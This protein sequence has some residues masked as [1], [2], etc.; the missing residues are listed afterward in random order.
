VRERA[1]R[2]LDQ[3][4]RAYL[5]GLTA[6]KIRGG[7]KPEDALRAARL[8]LGGVEQVKEQVRDVRRGAWFERLA[9]DVR[10]GARLL[11]RSPGFTAV[12]VATLALGIGANTALFSVVHALLLRPLPYRD[13]DRLVYIS[14]TRPG[15]PVA[16][17]PSTDF[18]NWQSNG[19]LFE[20]MEGFGGGGD[21]NL[22]G[23][24]EPERISGVTVTA[25]FLDL[26]GVRPAMGRNFTREEDRP[27]GPRAIVLSDALWRR[28]FGAAGDVVGKSVQLDERNYA[29]V[30]VLPASF[31]FPDNLYR[32][33]LLIP[34]R[35]PAAPVWAGPG[36][37]LLKA[38]ARLKPGGTIP[39]LRAELAALAAHTGS[40]APAE[41][42]EMHTNMQVTL[43]PLRE[44]LAGDARRV[45]L[46][47][48]AAVAMV[49]L[50]GCLNIANLEIGRAISRRKEMAL[51]AALGAGRARMARQLITES[52]L[53]SA[54]GA[55]AGLLLGYEGLRLL[56]R[57]LP[58]NL[59]LMTTARMDGTV[60]AF[61]AAVAVLTGVLT[62]LGPA[63]AG[64]KLN[65][66][67]WLKEGMGRT[68][69]GESHRRVRGVLVVAEIAVAIVLVAGAGLLM[70]SFLRLA[71]I[72]PGFDPHGV[73]TLEITLPGGFGP[74]PANTRYSSPE[75]RMAF[76]SQVV[77]RTAAIPGV[78]SA[79]IGMGLPVAGGHAFFDL[80]QIEGQPAPPPE[81]R[82]TV[83]FIPASP[84]YF[85]TLRIPLLRGRAF[86]DGDGPNSPPVMIVNQAFADQFF[87]G[88]ALGKHVRMDR[89]TEIV[90]IVGN[91]KQSGLRT[92]ESAI[93]YAPYRQSLM[94]SMFLLLR[95]GLPPA[96]L[97]GAAEKAVRAVDPNQ[98]V[99]DIATMDERMGESLAEDRAH[100]VLMG[101]L[102]G[103][104]LTLAAV[105]IFG[106]MAYS[107][108]RRMHEIGVRMALGAR[109]GDVLRMVFG[110]G[111]RLAWTGIGLGLAGALVLTRWI[112]ALLYRVS[113]TDPA[114]LAVVAVL[115]AAVAAAACAAPAR[116]AA[117]A[118][119]M[120]I[121]RHE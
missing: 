11:R 18:V 99:Y 3:E 4:L 80:D 36:Y 24:G 41:A 9:A 42:I 115:F 81:A 5:D 66:G 46:I 44:W 1:E 6:E 27:D 35:L 82:P 121:L 104:A 62:G 50:I 58:G 39:A 98:A 54:L 57:F 79:A 113:A 34:M 47:L 87:G 90:G 73:L 117:K 28:R 111:M 109:P 114:T 74:A 32:A 103:L 12:T 16:R 51:R 91:V 100:M 92:A 86:N 14:E 76:F 105:G 108:N 38:M 2:E 68:T 8:E 97:V 52:L 30:G 110:Q 106:V 89:W 71:A 67:E 23:L 88:P 65:L 55:S 29:V 49:L 63:L 19:K 102:G 37:R 26:I 69:S 61:T 112:G 83:P 116:W 78:E 77:E 59:H 107:V 48:Q 22:T 95:S 93:L 64:W 72:D 53:A 33:D 21:F 7:L 119:P 94:A 20:Q 101:I 84:D 56:R 40:E 45:V 15:A 31:I 60:L 43:T 70:R 25:G 120:V 118:D 17:V 10:Y 13:A 85:R 96:V 75:K